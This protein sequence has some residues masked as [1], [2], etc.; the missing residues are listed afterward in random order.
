M[1]LRKV[2]QTPLA[3][4]SRHPN[5]AGEKCRLKHF[6]A[7]FDPFVR[8]LGNFAIPRPKIAFSIYWEDSKQS[9]FY[10]EP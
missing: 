4:I 2:L 7:L 3:C 6:T 9:Y 1:P 10:S 5:M 8:I